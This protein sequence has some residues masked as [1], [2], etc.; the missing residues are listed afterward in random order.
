MVQSVNGDSTY[1]ITPGDGNAPITFHKDKAGA[2]KLEYTDE[3]GA[4]KTVEAESVAKFVA[5]HKEL[6]EK[7]GITDEGITYGGSRVSFKGGFQGIP[8]PR[9]FNRG[10]APVPP[11]LLDEEEERESLRAAGATFEKVAEALRAQLEIPGGQGLVVTRVDPGGAAESAG[12]RKSDILLEI[13]GKKV[14]SIK[15]VK[16]SLGKATSAVVLRKGKR[17]ALAPSDPKKDY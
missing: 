4:A 16:E 10:R 17:E 14:V 13:D 6:A 3:K 9:G 15:D 12:L 5:D 1:K 11:A 7:Y 8:L 2:V